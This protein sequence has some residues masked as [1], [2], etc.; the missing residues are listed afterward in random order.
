MVFRVSCFV[1]LC[2]LSVNDKM[3][4]D[5]E[6]NGKLYEL[7]IERDFLLVIIEETIEHFS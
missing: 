3:E 7:I 2:Y 5:L 4:D 1:L 6:R